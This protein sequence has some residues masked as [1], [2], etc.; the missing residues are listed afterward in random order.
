MLL[1]ATTAPAQVANILRLEDQTS[2]ELAAL[3]RSHCLLILVVAPVEQ[4]GPHLPLA[5]DVMIS[6]WLADRMGE[7]FA[8]E[9][10]DWT[11]LMPPPL[12]FSPAAA[13]EQ[14]FSI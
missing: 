2:A 12:V 8:R 7:R 6:A 3:D 1:S 5:T 14:Q 4:H 9:F 11:V 10:P 13:S